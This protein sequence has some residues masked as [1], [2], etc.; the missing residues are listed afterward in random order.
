MPKAAVANVS[1]PPPIEVPTP[2]FELI[3]L[4]QVHPSPLNPR[5]TF[6]QAK[7]AE[8]VESVRHKGVIAR[9]RSSTS[10]STASAGTA[11]RR[12]RA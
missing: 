5:K 2:A 4:V 8:L 9:S 3:P 7:H 10:S 6:D 1:T 12:R 11:R